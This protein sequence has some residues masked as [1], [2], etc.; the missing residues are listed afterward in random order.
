ML[1]HSNNSKYG[2]LRLLFTS[3]TVEFGYKQL[4]YKQH[5]VISNF[6]SFPG[7]NPMFYT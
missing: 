6:F 2:R 3:R 1:E 4:G 5:S 7:K